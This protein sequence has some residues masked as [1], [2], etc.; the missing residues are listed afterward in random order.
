MKQLIADINNRIHEADE[1]DKRLSA[2]KERI[3]EMEEF[4]KEV[5]LEVYSEEIYRCGRDEIGPG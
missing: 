4:F 5:D 3:E 2:I 1:I